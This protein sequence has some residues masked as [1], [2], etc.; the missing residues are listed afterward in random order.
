MKI[1][2]II[3]LSIISFAYIFRTFIDIA[4]FVSKY[5]KIILSKTPKSRDFKI[6]KRKVT[7]GCNRSY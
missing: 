2:S 3:Y 1:F 7:L 6:K 5:S 4:L